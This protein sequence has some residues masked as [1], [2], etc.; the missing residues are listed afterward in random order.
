M[1]MFL[2]TLLS[3]LM[4]TGCASRVDTHDQ[5]MAELINDIPLEPVVYLPGQ[6]NRE[7]LFD[8]LVAEMGGR[9]GYYDEALERYLRQAHLTQDA[10][11]AERATRIAQFLRNSEAVITAARLWSAAD[12]SA[13]EPKHLVVSILLH[14]RRFSEALPLLREVINDPQSDILMLV[15]TQSESLSAEVAREYIRLL[16]ATLQEQPTRS[17]VHLALGLLYLRENNADMAMRMFDQG[18]AHTPYYPPLI[19]QKAELLR[20]QERL[21]E[22]LR[23]VQETHSRHPH[24]QQIRIQ[25]AQLL[26]LSNRTSQ[27]E[28]LINDL[29]DDHTDDPELHIYFALLLLDHQRLDLSQSL[30][31]QLAELYPDMQEV[32]FYLGHIAQL[33]GQ[34]ELA[35]AHYQAVSGGSTF[36]QSRA[37]QLELYNTSEYLNDVIN[38]IALAQDTQPEYTTDL[39]ILLS[40][41]LTQYDFHQEAVK[42]LS[43]AIRIHPSDTR[44]LYTRALLYD[45]QHSSLMLADLE[46]ALSLDPSSAMIQNALG[47]SLLLH[48][49]DYDRAYQLIQAALEQK[50]EDPAILDSMGWVLFKLG[51]LQESLSYLQRAYLLYPDTEVAA[52]LIRV[53]SE[54]GQQDAAEELLS[55]H[56]RD[57]PDDRHLLN[58]AEK[59]RVQ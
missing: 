54:L 57:N 58:A 51:R 9:F 45:D 27:A 14:E 46:K 17:D 43:E 30:L 18:L 40:N 34:R 13:A 7:I 11:V 2:A 8:L 24:Q 38:T 28:R 32:Q 41:W 55:N 23:L 19:L 20:Q 3:A 22:A 56:L 12:P 26:L 53:L 29:L 21:N 31:N 1:K 6:L 42:H 25:Y 16:T 50:P 5:S 47:Y 15:S 44:L 36:L 10:A 49:N 4:L 39:T 52:H 33:Q 48:T 35:M 59:I 37:R